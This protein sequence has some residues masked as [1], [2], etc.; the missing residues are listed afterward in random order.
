MHDLRIAVGLLALVAA[1]LF[2]LIVQSL[3]SLSKPMLDT[4]AVMVVVV[5]VAYGYLMFGQLW[6]V[7]W[8]PAPAV[9]VLSN[10]IPLF[11]SALAGL[12]WLRLKQNSFRRTVAVC[13]LLVAA[14]YSVK[15]QF[16]AAPPQCQD[17]WAQPLV[18]MEWP[19]CLQ[20]TP[21]TCSAASSATILNTLGVKTTEQE[22]AELCLTQSGTSWLGL[23]HGLSVKLPEGSSVE[24][25]QTDID[26]LPEM[27]SSGPVLLC[28]RLDPSVAKIV[29]QYV[30][31][32]GWTPGLAHSVVYF[33]KQAGLH[34]V[35]DPSRGYEFWTAKDLNIL[36]TG[37]GLR[38]Q[39]DST[40]A[41]S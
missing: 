14:C 28:C 18:T 38:V 6:I 25:F 4:L 1:F 16:P 26:G 36:W 30:S 11:L 24:F 3:R 35:G 2:A 12:T 34:I 21:W 20:T 22:M 19:V 37:S 41:S 7:K 13:V 15:Y 29:P 31:N 23:Y 33:G 17:E 5:M 39:G 40:C 27:V 32:D 8:I 10:W 9:V